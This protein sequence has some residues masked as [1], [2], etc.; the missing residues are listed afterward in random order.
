VGVRDTST[1]AAWG[2]WQDGNTTKSNFG[3]LSLQSSD[4]F[5]DTDQMYAIGFLEGALTADR[6]Y[7]QV[8]N[9]KEVLLLEYGKLNSTNPK[10]YKPLTQFLDTN[11]K[12][13]RAQVAQHGSSDEFYRTLGLVLAQ[14]DGLVAGYKYAAPSLHHEPLTNFDFQMLNGV[15]DFFDLIPA[16]MPQLRRDFFTL[17]R[18]QVEAYVFQSGKCSALV[19][20]LGDFSNMFFSHTSWWSYHSMIR[21]MKHYS[22][23]LADKSISIRNVSFSSYPGFLESLDD[24]YLMGNGLVMLQTTN[25]LF[26]QSLYDLVTPHSVLAWQRVRIASLLAEDAE[27]WHGF[28]ARDNSGTYENQ[29]MVL[30]LKKFEPG[31]PLK[32]DTLWVGEQ[33]PG[34]YVAKDMTDQLE[35]G[36]WPSYNVPYHKQIYDLSGYPEMVAKF[37]SDLSYDLAPRAKIFRRDQ[38]SVV[39]MDTFKKIMRYNDY[40]NDPY[41]EGNPTNAICARA[42]LRKS[43]PSAGGCL[44]CK[45]SDYAMALELR[46]EVVN[47]PT[48]TASSYGPGQ[49]PFQWSTTRA[50]DNKS[51]VGQPDAF[52]FVFEEIE[53][54][55]TK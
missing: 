22:T 30:D 23:P 5:S 24:F 18:D 8:H 55:W 1:G 21:M 50:L 47:G 35:R 9:L 25:S 6:I 11:D 12:W 27:Q 49:T 48:S 2:S 34:H 17:P 20:L 15:G 13:C 32:Q 14:Y 46:S 4:K 31:Q 29:Y 16:V 39:D 36:Y 43:H 53:P 10:D 37:G 3:S 44:D 7:E 28:M 26:N 38:G 41:S 42:D 33:I 51:H 40:L 19:K 52:D 45:V 54:K